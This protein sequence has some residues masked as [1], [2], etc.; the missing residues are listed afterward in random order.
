MEGRNGIYSPVTYDWGVHHGVAASLLLTP[1][2]F[3]D[4]RIVPGRLGMLK[5]E[6]TKRCLTVKSPMGWRLKA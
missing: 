4:L 6:A 5:R 1:L 2:L 3:N